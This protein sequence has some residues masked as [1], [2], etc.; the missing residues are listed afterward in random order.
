MQQKFYLDLSAL[1][2]F[3]GATKYLRS[4]GIIFSMVGDPGYSL[5]TCRM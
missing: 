2:A 3:E 5:Y 1:W 4:P